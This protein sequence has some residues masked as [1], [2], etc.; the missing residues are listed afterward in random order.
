MNYNLKLKDKYFH[1]MKSGRKN[2][3]GRTPKDESDSMYDDMKVGDTITFTNNTSQEIMLCK[4]LSIIKFQNLKL[5]FEFIGIENALPDV[6]SIEE[7]I[8]IY[9]NISNYKARIEKF[10]IY[11]IGIK[12]M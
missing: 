9:N 12:P 3:E 7:G 8:E 2:I 5:M 1:L 11:A 10:G 6:D 4:I